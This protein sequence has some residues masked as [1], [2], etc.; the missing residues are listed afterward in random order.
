MGM[1]LNN[2]TRE[3]L[4]WSQSSDS[5]DKITFHTGSGPT[6]RMRITTAGIVTKPY[7]P[8][9]YAY[10][11]G[12]GTTLFASNAN[13]V[14]DTVSVNTGNHYS[15]STGRFTAPVSG[16]YHFSTTILTQSRS[17]GDQMEIGIYNS[18]GTLGAL[19]ART[20]Y[21]SNYTGYGG[22]ISGSCSCTFYLSA[23]DYM[24]VQNACGTSVYINSGPWAF[25]SGHLVG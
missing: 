8:A 10:M 12:G 20:I 14:F 23:G 1:Q 16:W 19:A 24:R 4:L 13:F 3:T 7:N 25:F 22:Y 9:F 15:T 18:A 5:D 2:V 11:N 17:N 21:Q 6:E